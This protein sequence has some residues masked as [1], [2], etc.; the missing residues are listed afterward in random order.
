MDGTLDAAR[1]RVVLSR[2][3]DLLATDR[4]AYRLVG[5]AA[6]VAQGVD[7]PAGDVD[8]LLR[9]RGDVDRV[10]AAL[11]RFPCA[12]APVWL[13][14]A[15][16]YFARFDVDGTDVELSTVEW[17]AGSDVCEGAGPGPWRHHVPVRM[18]A[19]VVPAV[20]VELRLV[21]ELVRDRPDRYEPLLAH[22]R[23]HGADLALVRRAMRERGVD[24]PLRQR[25][26]DRLRL[27]AGGSRGPRP[28][29]RS[30]R[31][32]SDRSRRAPP[33]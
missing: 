31:P 32:R 23:R 2:V 12:T 10:A 22:L 26:D 25:V 3:L 1:L 21:T 14:E 29:A 28:V 13:P 7:L 15:R 30:G 8:I 19:H 33:P 24:P 18:G 17:P 9:R 4:P 16:Q 20:R 5:T 6:A 11:S 27:T